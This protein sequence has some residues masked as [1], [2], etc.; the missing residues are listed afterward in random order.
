MTHDD[1]VAIAALLAGELNDAVAGS[2]DACSV[3][4]P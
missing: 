4:A 2:L 3:G 1:D